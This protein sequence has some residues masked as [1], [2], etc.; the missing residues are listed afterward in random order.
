MPALS[1]KLPPSLRYYD[2]KIKQSKYQQEMHEQDLVTEHNV[3]KRQQGL[4]IELQR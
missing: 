2:E 3:Q 4:Q 1:P